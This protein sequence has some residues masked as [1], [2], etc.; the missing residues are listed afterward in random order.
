MPQLSGTVRR[1]RASR[2]R[3]LGDER[4]DR[5]LASLAGSEAEILAE[6]DN[7]GYTQHYAPARIDHAVNPGEIVRVHITGRDGGTLTTNLSAP[8]AIQAA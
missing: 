8:S 3:M 6:K 2:L 7:R 5:Y 4:R 1:E